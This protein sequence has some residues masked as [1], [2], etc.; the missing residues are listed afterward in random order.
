MKDILAFDKKNKVTIKKKNNSNKWYFPNNRQ[1]AFEIS[2]LAS[3][4]FVPDA[5]SIEI[6]VFKK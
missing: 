2:E 5:K 1:K 3:S 4:Q 6:N